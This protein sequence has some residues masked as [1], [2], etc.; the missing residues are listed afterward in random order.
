MKKKKTIVLRVAAFW[1]LFALLLYPVTRV[2]AHYPDYRSYQ[3]IGGF[4][5]EADDSLDAVYL[6]S[7]NCYAFWNALIAWKNHGLTVFPYTCAGMPL[8][9]IEYVIREA[10]KTQPD[11]LYI[12]NINSVV[13]DAMDISH[14]HHVLS[15]M[16]DSELKRELRDH[17]CDL[18]G[19]GWS[20]RLELYLPWIRMR[21][22]WTEYL[23]EGIIPR[24][25]GMKAASHYDN[26]LSR[27]LNLTR[28]YR[29]T[30]KRTPITDN[31]RAC[32]EHL[33]DYCDAE[34]VRVL[35]VAVPRD[36]K[37]AN[38]LGR[39]N[40]A[41][42]LIR[43]RGH[44]VLYLTDQAD[45]VHL[46]LS[47]DFYEIKH[48]NIHGAIKFTNYLSEYLIEAYG[49]EDRRGDPAYASWDSGL[50]RYLKII[51][52]YVLDFELDVGNR[53]FTLKAPRGVEVAPAGDARA[54]I[55]WRPVK[56]A[57]VYCVYR[58]EGATGVWERVA[59]SE[60][61]AYVDGGLSGGVEYRYTVVPARRSG[62]DLLYGN[63]STFGRSITL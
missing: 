13:F 18:L 8:Y 22:Y 27:S 56:G 3:T 14:V 26:F 32:L 51:A 36:E 53:D 50:A 4:Y 29:T 37:T 40:T 7:S 60:D 59:V 1:A 34:G 15:Y 25:D 20:E 47:Q 35:F 46:D 16:P 62:E 23:D 5:E 2:F 30:E 41:C 39:I 10:R 43:E 31:Q 52:P 12:V 45:A 33:M 9:A 6:G 38:L 28:R 19:L 11:A 42:D 48:T 44:D 54:E 58:K 63:F 57:E 24:V 17:L 55:A 61:C 21:Q 49:L